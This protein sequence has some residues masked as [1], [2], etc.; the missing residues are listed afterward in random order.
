MRH[1]VPYGCSQLTQQIGNATKPAQQQMRQISHC[2]T[3][4]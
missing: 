3:G 4:F 2:M 1:S